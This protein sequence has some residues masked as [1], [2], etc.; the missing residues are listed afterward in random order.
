MHSMSQLTFS[1]LF[2]G[3]GNEGKLQNHDTFT[4]GSVKGLPIEPGLNI[5]SKDYGNSSFVELNFHLKFHN[6]LH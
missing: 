5:T 1:N 2:G 4:K 6:I 3:Y